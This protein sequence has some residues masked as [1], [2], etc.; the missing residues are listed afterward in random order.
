MSRNG[1]GC[2]WE[3]PLAVDDFPADGIVQVLSDQKAAT[4][5]LMAVNLK[6]KE[7]RPWLGQVVK[8]VEKAKKQVKCQQLHTTNRKDLVRRNLAGIYRAVRRRMDSQ[9]TMHV[10]VLCPEAPQGA[11]ICCRETGSDGEP[12][13]M[14][15]GACSLFWC[16]L[17]VG[18]TFKDQQKLKFILNKDKRMGVIESLESFLGS[19]RGRNDHGNLLQTE[20]AI[21]R[22]AASDGRCFGQVLFETKEELP[23]AEL[24][25]RFLCA[26]HH[27]LEG[28]NNEALPLVLED[29]SQL[30]KQSRSAPDLKEY[31]DLL[32]RPIS[33]SQA[34]LALCAV[35]WLVKLPTDSGTFARGELVLVESLDRTYPQDI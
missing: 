11:E 28:E 23:Q 19:F 22:Q 13:L 5:A 12:V 15:G 27:R 8:I 30:C 16:T 21:S 17:P 18:P 35:T 9:S 20:V 25:G 6:S 33:S 2:H 7:L 24:H 4:A 10:H 14:Q 1:D 3:L 29:F 31:L 26:F 34:V 32:S